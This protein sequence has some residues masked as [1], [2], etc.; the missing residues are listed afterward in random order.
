M[1]ERDLHRLEP[2]IDQVEV[3]NSWHQMAVGRKTAAC[4]D[5]H[6]FLSPL[7]LE[8]LSV[9][10]LGENKCKVCAWAPVLAELYR[11]SR[12]SSFWPP[13]FIGIVPDLSKALQWLAWCC[14]ACIIQVKQR[15]QNRPRHEIPMSYED[16]EVCSAFEKR[17]PGGQVQQENRCTL[18]QHMA[19]YSPVGR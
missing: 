11:D 17:H 1:Q 6:N 10:R 18:M 16:K 9:F 8:K 13:S 19:L 14:I 2:N 4:P 15:Y 5:E 12:L 3:M 7:L